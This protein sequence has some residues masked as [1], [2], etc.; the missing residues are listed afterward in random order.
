MLEKFPHPSVEFYRLL[1]YMFKADLYIIQFEL[2]HFILK[3]LM[4]YIA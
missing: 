3:F 2:P 1:F 4:K